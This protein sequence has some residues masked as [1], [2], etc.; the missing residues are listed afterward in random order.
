MIYDYVNGDFIV[1]LVAQI[2]MA[3]HEFMEFISFPCSF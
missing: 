3:M 1:T 2:A